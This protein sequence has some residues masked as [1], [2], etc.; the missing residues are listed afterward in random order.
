MSTSVQELTNPSS[1][2]RQAPPKTIVRQWRNAVIFTV[3]AVVTLVVC[4][5]NSIEDTVVFRLSES[6]D[7]IRLGDVQLAATPTGWVLGIVTAMMAV[8]AWVLGVRGRKVPKWC[9]VVF[10]AAFVIAM[11]VWAVSHADSNSLS[12]PGLLGGSL[13]LAVPLIFGSMSGLLC[14]RSGVVNIA[15]EGQLLF[16]AFAAAVAGS[17][18]HN[19]WVGLVAAMFGAVLVSLILAI[20]TIKYLVNQVIVGVVVNVL[21]SG[22]TGFLYSTVL[23]R[24]NVGLNAPEHL[25]SFSIPF[26]SKIPVVGPVLFDQSVIVYLM[27]VVVFLIWYGLTKTRWGLR[28]RAVGEHPKAAD[29]LGVKVNRLRF[30]NVLLAGAVAGMGGAFFTLVSVSSFNKDMTA[31]QGYIALAALIFGRWRPFGALFAALLFGFATNLQ[32]VLSLLGTTVP[33]QFLAMLPYLVTIA[34]VTGLVGRSRGPAAS[35]VPYVKE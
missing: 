21:V 19:A 9:A 8:I 22:L 27:Y 11:L 30:W 6:G 2:S 25:P 14:E 28:T 16:G 32:S 26:L 10:W 23:S 34:A 5:L 24:S 15:I 31:G 18:A 1:P 12:L 3:L 35:G 33:S 4:G 29:T 13:T 17:V 20:F 7:A